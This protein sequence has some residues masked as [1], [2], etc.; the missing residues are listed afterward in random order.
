[1]LLFRGDND[2]TVVLLLFFK[3]LW[4]YRHILNQAGIKQDEVWDLPLNSQAAWWGVPAQEIQDLVAAVT[5]Y[6]TA[7]STVV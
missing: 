4:F 5:F 3:N 6:H 1:M 7:F 2:V